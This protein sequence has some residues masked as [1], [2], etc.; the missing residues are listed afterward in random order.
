[1]CLDKVVFK[2]VADTNKGSKREGGE[3]K[4]RFIISK[5]LC[6]SD[7]TASDLQ[8]SISNLDQL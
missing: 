4:I 7:L 1:M 3:K 5:E 6:L 2:G 8:L